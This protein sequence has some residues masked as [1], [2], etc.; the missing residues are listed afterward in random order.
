MRVGF[1]SEP[2]LLLFRAGVALGDVVHAAH[3]G[4]EER[5]RAHVL[6]VSVQTNREFLLAHERVRASLAVHLPPDAP[7]AVVQVQRLLDVFVLVVQPRELLRELR[8]VAV[9]GAHP[10]LELGQT[11]GH[12]RVLVPE[13]V[14]QA[15]VVQRVEAAA[16]GPGRGGR[17]AVPGEVT[18]VE[19]L[20][21]VHPDAHAA[22]RA[23]PRMATPANVW[24]E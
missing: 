23:S 20:P 22:R 24:A 5:V 17:D 16:E 6:T 8:D 18:Q 4:V 9:R 19:V 10:T 14:R 7:R 3:R 15:G 12:D 1:C 21:R 2:S 11:R 13:P